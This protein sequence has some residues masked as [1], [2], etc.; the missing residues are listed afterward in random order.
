LEHEHKMFSSK[1][2]R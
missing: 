1:A 2:S